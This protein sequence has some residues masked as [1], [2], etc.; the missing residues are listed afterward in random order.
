MNRIVIFILFFGLLSSC[1]LGKCPNKSDFL[2]SFDAFTTNIEEDKN[3]NW[4]SKDKEFYQYMNDCYDLYDKELTNSEKAKLWL[5][6]VKY[7]T[8]KHDGRL[9][10]AYDEAKEK[11]KPETVKDLE[12]FLETYP[13][14][15]ISNS[16]K[17]G[18]KMLNKFL[19]SF[20]KNVKP[21]LDKLGDELEKSSKELQKELEK[22]AKEISGE[23][24]KSI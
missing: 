6:A 8:A 23:L 19:D 2:S 22:T 1:H 17:T 16:V 21:E 10:L 5:G 15:A 14:E 7:Y 3:L 24:E 11:L 13:R 18:V 12:I 9:D 4:E 20:G